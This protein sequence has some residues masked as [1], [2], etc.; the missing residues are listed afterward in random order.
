MSD[1]G[2]YMGS[3]FAVA[4]CPVCGGSFSKCGLPNHLRRHQRSVTQ[5]L[6][7]DS[8]NHR[9]PTWWD[10]WKEGYRLGVR[11]GSNRA[12]KSTGNLKT[13]TH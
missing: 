8:G 12:L 6:N 7:K 3:N 4:K 13:K 2:I 10:G 9:S 5:K 1:R 11:D